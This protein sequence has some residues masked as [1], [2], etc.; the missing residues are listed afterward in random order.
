MKFRAQGATNVGRV[1][2]TNQDSYLIKIADTPL[3]Q[4]A[5]V[6]VCDGMGGLAK[7]ELASA[8]VVRAM[9]KWFEEKLPVL[10]DTMG[11]S[12][13]G[14]ESTVE[15]QWLG[16]VQ[17][18]NIKIMR[19]GTA[20]KI[21]L[22]TTVTAMLF[23]GAR[24][25]ILNV[26]DTRAYEITKDSETQLTRDQTFVAQEIEAGR[27]TVEEA[28]VHPQ[29]NVLLQC[30]GSSREVVPEVVHGT[31]NKDAT[32]LICSDGFRHVLEPGELSD[33]FNKLELAS[34]WVNNT[35]SEVIN[36]A[37]EVVM[38]RREKDNIT[39][40]LLEAVES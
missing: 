25:S 6:C 20:D 28:K 29:R 38:E 40:V 17:D 14:F 22:G 4:V 32:Y 19:Y 16:L 27:M 12:V 36:S 30:V 7:G 35:I 1:K 18:L 23:M 15:G 33:T 5:L 26:G 31:L 8:E 10:I 37:I 13:E 9:G 39:A 3:G 24:Y 11:S 21:N 34:A 2:K